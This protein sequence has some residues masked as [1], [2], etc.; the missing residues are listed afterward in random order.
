MPEK[1]FRQEELLQYV[2]YFFRKRGIKEKKS[3]QLVLVKTCLGRNVLETVQITQAYLPSQQVSGITAKL[4][5][6]NTK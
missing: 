6:L 4:E 1:F 5:E 2:V 3:T